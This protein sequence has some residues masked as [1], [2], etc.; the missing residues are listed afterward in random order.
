MKKVISVLSIL[1]ALAVCFLSAGCVTPENENGLTKDEVWERL[2]AAVIEFNARGFYQV[3]RQTEWDYDDDTRD[4]TA[5]YEYVQ[6]GN[7]E[8][9][10]STVA[11]AYSDFELCYDGNLYWRRSNNPWQ[12]AGEYRFVTSVE[13][14][15]PDGAYENL[16]WT[17]TD[18]GLVV[19]CEISNDNGETCTYYL[20]SV[21]WLTKTVERMVVASDCVQTSTLTIQNPTE[22]TVLRYL[23][24]AYEDAQEDTKLPTTAPEVLEMGDLLIRYV[25]AGSSDY[26]DVAYY[27]FRAGKPV[28]ISVETVNEYVPEV[29]YI[30]PDSHIDDADDA[31][32][33]SQWRVWLQYAPEVS[34]FGDAENWVPTIYGE[35][36]RIYYSHK[37]YAME[38]SEYFLS[39]LPEIVTDFHGGNLDGFT[40]AR[41]LADFTIVNAN[42]GFLVEYLDDLYL[43]NG[44]YKLLLE[45]ARYNGCQYDYCTVIT[46]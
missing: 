22:E 6:H 12:N 31:L 16:T 44:S 32:Q 26:R 1:L 5:V 45:G 34:Q 38:P 3:T 19:V 40:Y 25:G 24:Q 36:W 35:H 27:V 28:E 41:T 7:N 13:V 29:V 18:G 37:P 20:D 15:L 43:W 42:D 9:T 46:P 11:N 33:A 17:E 21:G 39:I 14:T 4:Q 23:A 8:H 2:Q 10:T 30:W